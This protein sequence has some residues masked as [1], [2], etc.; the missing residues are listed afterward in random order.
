MQKILIIE[1]NIKLKS[2]LAYLLKKYGYEAF[3]I[4]DFDNIINEFK[5]IKPNLILLDINLPYF[6]GY[7]FCRQIR[8]ISDVPIIFITSRNNTSDE[9]LAMTIGGDDFITKP[10]NNEVLLSRI[11][12]ILKRYNGA[13]NVTETI[14]DNNL[15][16]NVVSN[17]IE[18]NEVK[19]ELTK[20]E[21]KLLA[22]LMRNKGSIV[23]R[24]KLIEML[25]DSEEYVNENTLSVNINRIRTKLDELGLH[26]YIT[27]VRGQGYII[28]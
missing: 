2:E 16:L 8:E 15:T 3:E 27:T 12:A 14:T 22:L 21:Q 17:E 5:N 4:K 18:Y 24:V 10:F 26:E 13:N 23:S 28:K 7:H 1:D 25:W 20:N 9:I 6:D 11:A 19:I